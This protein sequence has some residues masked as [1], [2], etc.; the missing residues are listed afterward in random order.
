[1]TH[2]LKSKNFLYR[3]EGFLWHNQFMFRVLLVDSGE[4]ILEILPILLI[5]EYNFEFVAAS[6]L[7]EAIKHLESKEFQLI[8]SEYQLDDGNAVPLYEKGLAQLGIPFILY[9]DRPLDD[10]QG[11]ENFLTGHHQNR[12]V[13]KSGGLDP[14]LAVIQD[15]MVITEGDLQSAQSDPYRPIP[16]HFFKKYQP[17]GVSLFIKLSEHKYVKAFLEGEI[18]QERLDHYLEKKL[19]CFYIQREDFPKLRVD[20]KSLLQ[21]QQASEFQELSFAQDVLGLNFDLCFDCMKELGLDEEQLESVNKGVNNTIDLVKNNN[22]LFGLFKQL[23][24][25]GSFLK[26]HSLLTLYIAGPIAIEIGEWDSNVVIEKMGLAAFFHDFGLSKEEL[27]IVENESFSNLRLDKENLKALRN[28]PRKA[29]E[30]L[31]P[32]DE[33]SLDTLSIIEHHHE[34]PDGSGY[35]DGLKGSEITELGAL[36][37][38]SH[39]LACF[40]IQNDYDMKKIRGFLMMNKRLYSVGHYLRP[41]QTFCKM[42]GFKS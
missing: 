17:Q 14:L 32:F 28:H 3:I 9:S 8:I 41:Y 13:T 37:N 20:L 25:T 16:I 24:K 31:D 11:L 4:Q 19:D 38:F 22:D 29:V 21:S 30:L 27:V 33:L 2:L 39:N 1:M 42:I 40:I 12:L 6:S 35:P 26:D 36:F 34:L 23:K 10:C 18:D 5:S 15:C 7:A